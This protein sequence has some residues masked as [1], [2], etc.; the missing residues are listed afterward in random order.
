MPGNCFV[1]LSQGLTEP[2]ARGLAE[3]VGQQVRHP[4]VSLT[5]WCAAFSM[6]GGDSSSGTHAS[7]APKFTPPFLYRAGSSAF[8][9]LSSCIKRQRMILCEGDLNTK[10]YVK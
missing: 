8:R 6:G 5:L 1:L 4:P 2:G 7:T 3:L 10:Y 9:G